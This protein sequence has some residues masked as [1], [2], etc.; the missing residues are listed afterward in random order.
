MG[1]RKLSITTALLLFTFFGVQGQAADLTAS[2]ASPK[3]TFTDSD[4]VGTSTISVNKRTNDTWFNIYDDVGNWLI[5]GLLTNDS[6]RSIDIAANGN[7]NLANGSV[8][9]ERLTNAVGVGTTTPE[10]DIHVV[11]T[12]TTTVGVFPL[13]TTRGDATLKLDA[14]DNSS[15]SMGA[16]YYK[17]TLGSG[18][19]SFGITDNS[20]A[21]TPFSIYQGASANSLN[22]YSSNVSIGTKLNVH[23]T[24]SSTFNGATTAGDGLT[25]VMTLEATNSDA[26]K[27][28]DTAFVLRNGRTGKQW[29]FRTTK[30]GDGF[31]ATINGTGGTEFEIVNDTTDFHNTKL[32]IGGKLVFANGKIQAG[33]LP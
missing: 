12:S 9:I 2:S 19:K 4:P 10:E 14:Y 5:H 11:N 24:I 15:W 23:D 3:I 26:S 22:I 31:A 25:T 7:I 33:V 32:Y 28:S 8:F 21:N 29:N 18:I 20:T 1:T 17:T 30:D 6:D 16:R 13:T 27:V